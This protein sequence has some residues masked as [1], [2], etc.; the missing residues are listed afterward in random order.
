MHHIAFELRD[1]AHV[2]DACDHLAKHGRELIWG[3]G[4]HGI[5]HNIFI[6]HRNPDDQIV[7]LFTELDL[8]KDE[9]LGY[10]EPRPWHAD[11]PQRP[12]VWQPGGPAS[13]MWGGPPP[14][15]FRD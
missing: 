6:Y 7:E 15:G 3:P 1:W 9:A 5:G 10:F 12:K 11:R 13:N 14:P 8:M 4:R 2:H